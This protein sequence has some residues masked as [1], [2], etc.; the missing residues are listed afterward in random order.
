MS[1]GIRGRQLTLSGGTRGMRSTQIMVPVTAMAKAETEKRDKCQKEKY[2]QR[3][4]G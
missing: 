1:H 3:T 2:L 4:V